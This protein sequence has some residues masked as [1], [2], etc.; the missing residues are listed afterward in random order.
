MG[1]GRKYYHKWYKKTLRITN[2]QRGDVVFKEFPS[3]VPSKMKR[4]VTDRSMNY[5]L[6][7]L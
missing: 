6:T 5:L 4:K 3:L 2:R 1:C 7:Y